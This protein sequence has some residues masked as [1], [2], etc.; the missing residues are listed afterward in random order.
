MRC[1]IAPALIVLCFPLLV[2]AS[3]I[4]EDPYSLSFYGRLHVSTDYLYDGTAGGLNLSSNSS[5]LGVVAEHRIH[6]QLKLLGQIERTIQVSDGSASLTSR[7]T[8]IGLQGDFGTLR[9]GF[10]DTPVKRILNTVEQFRARVGEGR[11]ITRSGDMDFDR[12]FRNGLQYSSPAW[13][14]WSFA[15]HYGAGN[16]PDVSTTTQDDEW[17]SML[18]WR[19]DAWH[20]QVGYEVRA[21][22]DLAAL[23]AFRNAIVYRGDGWQLASFL[24]Y[25]S[26]MTSGRTYVYGLSG[27]YQLS[28][29]Y[30]LKGQIFHRE[31][32]T[33]ERSKGS[34]FAV[35]IDKRL[36]QYATSY[37]VFAIAE[38]DK[39]SQV[40][41]SAGGHGTTMSIV[42]GNDPFAVSA[43][44]I[45]SF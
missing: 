30:L 11:N 14:H 42:M 29:D 17:S 2:V 13:N 3:P 15:L 44:I 12:R 1:L 32:G 38:N 25:A 35:G 31:E 37:V 40:N 45:W 24:Q 5:R 20:I 39:G 6:E 26:G 10:I 19:K 18:Q 43:G 22:E 4:A 8:F 9:A 16:G 23:E 27:H 34:L 36:S 28:S 41:V 7:N 33:Q 21:R